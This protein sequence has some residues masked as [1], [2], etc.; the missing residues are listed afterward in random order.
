ME[1]ELFYKKAA[2]TNLYRVLK[3]LPPPLDYSSRN[4]KYHSDILY[5]RGYNINQL[6]SDGYLELAEE[7]F[8][9]QKDLV[10]KNKHSVYCWCPECQSF[11]INMPLQTVCGNCGYPKCTTYYDVHTINDNLINP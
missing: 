4:D 8:Q 10:G 6:V 7:P 1:K 3:P 5:D 11:G 2:N 9:W